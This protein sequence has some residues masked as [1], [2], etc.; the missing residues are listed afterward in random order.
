MLI[1]LATYTSKRSCLRTPFANERV[2]G[3]QKLLKSA[4]HHYYP[5]FL[6]IYGKLSWKKSALVWYEILRL[7]F[8]TLT[9]D[10]KY[11]GRCMQSLPQQ[12]QTSLSRK[13]KTFSDFLL[14][15]WNV[16]EIWNILNKEMSLLAYLF[17]K[18][19]MLRNV[20]T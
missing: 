9:A 5:L 11:S 16:H 19:L 20:A 14:H 1:G 8:K 12:F 10:D 18:L 4:R 7:F 17:P 2:N 6:S 13:K 15:F 3:F